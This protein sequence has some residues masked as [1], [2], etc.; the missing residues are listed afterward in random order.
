[1]SFQPTQIPGGNLQVWLDAADVNGNGTQPA[2]GTNVSS[3]VDKSGNGRNFSQV[4]AGNQPL[5]T[6]YLSNPAVQFTG[7]SSQ[8]L[9]NNYVQTGTGA[10][11]TFL[12]FADISTT[13]NLYGNPVMFYMAEGSVSGPGVDWRTGFDGANE[14]LSIDIRS[15]AKTMRRTPNVTSMR[16][17]PTLA[18]W[19]APESA[20]VSSAFVFGNGTQFTTTVASINVTTSINTLN[21]PP[22][23]V[24]GGQTGF[25][26]FALY[27][28]LHF[29]T[30]L[31][32]LQ[33]Q[34]VEG[35]LAWKWGVQSSLPTT[36]PYYNFPPTSLTIQSG[37]QVNLVNSIV[38]PGTVL[39]PSSF[40]IP[41][42]NLIFKDITGAFST[43]SL[44]LT[45]NNANQRIESALTSTINSN[46]LGWTNLIAGNNNN[47]F[48]VG[49]TNINTINT[50]TLNAG[51]MSTPFISTGTVF[52][53]TLGL[54]DQTWANST[55]SIYVQSTF[56]YYQSQG[57]NTIISGSRQS[58]G[59]TFIITS[60]QFQPNRIAGLIA[61]LDATDPNTIIRTG[62]TV[63]T[64]IDK[65]GRRNNATVAAGTLTYNSFSLGGNP[66]LTIGTAAQIVFPTI[67]FASGTRSVFAVVN[68]GATGSFYIF[69]S[70]VT[71]GASIQ[72]YADIGG[73]L[74]YSKNGTTMLLVNSPP[75]FYN[76]TSILCGTNVSNGLFIN[77]SQVT[78]NTNTPSAF[79]TG[80]TNQYLGQTAGPNSAYNMGEFLM[81]DSAITL[82]GQ[83][84]QVEGYLAWKWGLVANLPASHPFKNSPP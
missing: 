50:S 24:G 78:L 61:W 43:N 2:I 68:V 17:Q 38:Q 75:T 73:S 22:T 83:Q 5:F 71:V 1:M 84:Q 37:T 36:H 81:Y 55:N 58:F 13:A 31:P 28:L 45:V 15:G 39:L 47:W 79:T 66:F 30:N 49:G 20:N 6:T 48:T 40:A 32:T 67:N 69:L 16:T 7:S 72:F 41:G 65:S 51:A 80:A 62:N 42:R 8:S 46:R 27:E 35:Y 18:L 44:T 76:T 11:N 29:N 21:T 82:P 54:V 12:V 70:G 25:A 53:S 26:T 23:R 57:R 9:S 3:W 34:Q 77:G 63:T 4:N 10:R 60:G 64:W 19:G 74:Q 59:G 33:R 14:Y 56:M 52:L